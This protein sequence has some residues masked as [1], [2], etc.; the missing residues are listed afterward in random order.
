MFG[1]LTIYD[2]CSKM[3][4]GIRP[5]AQLK[6]DR[7]CPRSNLSSSVKPYCWRHIS[8]MQ[9]A[10]SMTITLHLGQTRWI[11]IVESLRAQ[12]NNLSFPLSES[13]VIVERLPGRGLIPIFR[14]ANLVFHQ[15]DVMV[16]L[17]RRMCSFIHQQLVEQ[18]CRESPP[19]IL[20]L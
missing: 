12:Y 11:P 14:G 18:W 6:S 5:P 15:W 7:S 17:G 20:V 19:S 2:C 1:W 13:Q 9:R 3:T 8:E 16:S 10:S 4:A